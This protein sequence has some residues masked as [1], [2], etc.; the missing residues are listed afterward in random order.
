MYKFDFSFDEYQRFLNR[1]PFTEEE[2]QI[3]GMRRRNKSIS[4]IALELN[5]SER[6]VSRYIKSICKKIKKEI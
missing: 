1:C 6:T 2:I 4:Q 5:L 3:L